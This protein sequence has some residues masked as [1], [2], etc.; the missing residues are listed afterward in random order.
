MNSIKN[1]ITGTI[2]T[3]VIG[4]TAYTVSQSDIIK[5]FADD[6]GLSQEQAEQYVNAI[7]EEDLVTFSELGND[8]IDGGRGL[9]NM[10]NDIDCINYEYEW[11]SNTLSCP[12]AKEQINKIYRDTNSL[13]ILFRKLDSD[14]ASEED[15]YETIRL[16]DQLNYDYQ[17][18]VA[19]VLWDQPT[20]DGLKKTN[21][22][23]K[24]L[25]KAALESN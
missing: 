19:D 8:L 21:S 6:T 9:L 1:I 7:P 14:S 12:N 23:N 15:I 3:V 4:G 5:N 22:Y 25:L 13:G 20:I 16:I 2:I 24:A 18:E 11:E 17:L 10:A